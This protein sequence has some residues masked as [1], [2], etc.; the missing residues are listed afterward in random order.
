MIRQ[1]PYWEE[2]ELQCLAG[3]ASTCARLPGGVKQPRR[4]PEPVDH[5]RTRFQHDRDRILH[6]ASFRKLQHKTQVF[7]THEGDLYRTRMTHTLETTQIASAV[8]RTMGLN[9]VLAES[10]A[11][12]HDIGHAPFGHGGEEELNHLMKDSGGFDHNIHSLRLVD[13][14]ESSY[15]DFSGLNLCWETREGLARHS[16]PFDAPGKESGFSIHRQPSPECQVVNLADI[17]AWCTHDLDDALRIG[18][19]NRSWLEQKSGRIPLLGRVA[20]ALRGGEARAQ[21]PGDAPRTRAVSMMINTLI[22][23]VVTES[24]ARIDALGIETV[25]DVRNCRE[26]CIAFSGTISR[27]VRELLDSMVREVY[28]HPLVNRMVYKG[29]HIIRRLFEILCEH[30]DIMRP[31]SGF[32]PAVQGPR[33]VC[34]YI[35]GLTDRSAMDL[36]SMLFEPYSRTTD[37]F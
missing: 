9:T 22:S 7:V 4:H 12:A 23:D 25:D 6:S 28:L 30:P 37:W 13:V 8:S 27:Q 29:K 19:L 11:M 10:I 17:I 34:D 33:G 31:A 3:Y 21:P 16:T 5:Y 35:A 36:Y 15:T 24:T 32:R 1:A 26:E 20:E 2:Q 18:L 14:L